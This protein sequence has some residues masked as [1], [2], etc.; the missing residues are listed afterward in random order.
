MNWRDWL[1]EKSGRSAT[2][3]LTMPGEFSL[4]PNALSVWIADNDLHVLPDQQVQIP[5]LPL[6]A[7]VC[8]SYVTRGLAEIGQREIA[9]VLA[10]AD[11][12]LK[13]KFER[14]VFDVLRLLYKLACDGR[15]VGFGDITIFG[16]RG[17]FDL[18]GC[19]F[20]YL[21]STDGPGPTLPKDTLLALF[22]RPEECAAANIAG[23]YRAVAWIA[24][25]YRIFPYP[26]FSDPSR[27]TTIPEGLPETILAKLP[28]V[29][30][31]RGAGVFL[32]NKTIVLRL[33]GAVLN[34]LATAFSATTQN[35][36]F[37]LVTGH[38][39]Y[40]NGRLVWIPKAEEPEAIGP[41]GSSLST[42]E[43]GFLVLLGGQAENKAVLVEDG[44]CAM[45]RSDA[46]SILTEAIGS[47]A[48]AEIA[49]GGDDDRFVKK[50]RIEFEH[51]AGQSMLIDFSRV[52]LYLPDD[53][54]SQRLGG[55]ASILAD[56]IAML[57]KAAAAFW[58]EFAEPKAKGLFV[59]VGV[60][61]YNKTKV[62]CE[63]V[64]GE[65]PGELLANLEK[66]LGEVPAFAAPEGPIAFAIEAGLWHQTAD[67]Y[68]ALPH[69]WVVAC[70]GS[71]DPLMI[72]DELFK[73]IWPEQDRTNQ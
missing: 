60:C 50:F 46:W 55:D 26:K 2:H 70:T 45:F 23:V 68:P 34:D 21:E 9:F 52:R 33:R 61:G 48:D 13:T 16:D 44:F 71:D 64:G 19:D 59:A 11:V 14:E 38:V 56:Y 72:P 36:C 35:P 30:A 67:E 29:R 62:W 1:G 42:T 69:A 49:M 63:A 7:S 10:V 20:A 6:P 43:G 5:N 4:L 15:T 18:P 24:R 3:R 32:R 28:V 51:H 39:S 41:S 40:A 53:I 17:P 47:R 37:A 57:E 12:R 8:R 66:V 73:V 27:L 31:P 58:A 22:L 25:A 65:I 54:L